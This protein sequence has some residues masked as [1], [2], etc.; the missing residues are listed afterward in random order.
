[1]SRSVCTNRSFIV[2][3]SLENKPMGL[4]RLSHGIFA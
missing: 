2:S 1:M 3:M 4:A